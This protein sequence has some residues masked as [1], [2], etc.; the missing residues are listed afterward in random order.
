VSEDRRGGVATTSF[1]VA[2]YDC[3]MCWGGPEEGGWW[4]DAGTLVRIVKL[5]KTEDAAYQYCRRLNSKLE[6]RVFGPNQ[7]KHSYTSVLSESELRASVYENVAPLGFPD[8]RP[9]YE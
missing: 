1:V 4:Y 9:H 3:S 7:G 5:F 2:V 8:H 6:S